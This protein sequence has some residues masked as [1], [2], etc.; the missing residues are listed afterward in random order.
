M[1]NC[2][3]TPVGSW[4]CH[5]LGRAL[6]QPSIGLLGAVLLSGPAADCARVWSHS[7][8]AI[9]LWAMP[10]H[11]PTL[12]HAPAWSCAGLCHSGP[13]PTIQFA[14]R[15]LS[16]ESWIIRLPVSDNSDYILVTPGAAFMACPKTALWGMGQAICLYAGFEK[17]LIGSGPTKYMNCTHVMGHVMGFGGE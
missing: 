8:S 12:G 5:S 15:A 3:T 2:N 14:L 16:R 11:S 6:V 9:L 4:C 1:P 10:Q 7:L 13:C 17:C